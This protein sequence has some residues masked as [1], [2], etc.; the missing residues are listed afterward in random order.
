MYQIQLAKFSQNSDLGNTLCDTGT[1]VLAEASLDREWGVG[2]TVEQ[3]SSGRVPHAVNVSWGK[4]MCGESL[5]R[6]REH[7]QAI[8]DREEQGPA[9]ANSRTQDR[10][11]RSTEYLRRRRRSRNAR[12]F[13]RR[14]ERRARAAAGTQ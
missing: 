4:N 14:A 3:F 10:Q 1:L 13:K 2:F 6:V 9:P 12:L 5:M 7:L 8:K 11:D